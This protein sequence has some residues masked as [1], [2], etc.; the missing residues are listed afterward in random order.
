MNKIITLS[1]ALLSKSPS[2]QRKTERRTKYLRKT[3]KIERYQKNPAA[4]KIALNFS[5]KPLVR[6]IS[7]PVLKICSKLEFQI[8]V[9][10]CHD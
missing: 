6:S 9:G 5:P 7:V 4:V 10:N 3:R 2:K 8:M 1:Q